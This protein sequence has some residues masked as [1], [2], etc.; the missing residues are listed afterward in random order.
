MVAPWVLSPDG[1]HEGRGREGNGESQDWLEAGMLSMAQSPAV[2]L[3]PTCPPRCSPYFLWEKACS[4]GVFKSAR[5]FQNNVN[6]CNKEIAVGSLASFTECLNTCHFLWN[7]GGGLQGA[8]F[9]IIVG[10]SPQFLTQGL[11]RPKGLQNAV[12]F[13]C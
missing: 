13:S 9:A 10:L 2:L 7:G 4:M 8:S 11:R 3:N 6:S 5:T 12:T 1:S